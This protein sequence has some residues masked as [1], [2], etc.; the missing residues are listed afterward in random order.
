MFFV[1][2]DNA[3]I[4]AVPIGQG[5]GFTFGKAENVI[6]VRRYE[7]AAQAGSGDTGRTYDVSPDGKRFL[8][9]SA[10]DSSREQIVV[11]ENWASELKSAKP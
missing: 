1:T 6:D 3:H 4:A 11:V 5:A 9:F 2:A 7:M 8:V 10:V